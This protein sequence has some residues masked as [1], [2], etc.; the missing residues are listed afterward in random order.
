MSGRGENIGEEIDRIALN[1]CELSK[2]DIITQVTKIKLSVICQL[3]VSKFYNKSDS[4]TAAIDLS[5]FR[6]KSIKISYL[7]KI[8]VSADRFVR[9]GRSIEK[10][11]SSIL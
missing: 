11:F 4:S 6:S 8:S 9:F 7:Q 3:K 1:E 2:L 5:F 10:W